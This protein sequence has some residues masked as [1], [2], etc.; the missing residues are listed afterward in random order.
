[1]TRLRVVLAMAWRESRASRR[2]L[3]L[4]ASAISI[5]V[6]AL[7]AIGSFTANLET[8]VRREA[9]ELLG[10]DLAL[11]SR[12]PF[13]P[14]IEALL[15]S[16]ARAGVKVARRTTF[17]S[18]GYVRRT[19]GI[20]LVEVRAVGAGFPFYGDVL[21]NPPGL[22]RALDTG[23][24]A[25][26]DTS[27]LVAL[28]ARVG[29]TL[30]LGRRSFLIAAA[31][32]EVPGHLLGGL[33]AFG[34]QVYIPI[35]D[36]AGTGL[37][38][39][40]SRVRHSALFRFDDPKDARRLVSRHRRLF[41]QERVSSQ[42]AEETQSEVNDAL[43]DLS[44]FLQFVGLVALLLGGIGVA[45]GVGAFVA[46]KLETVAVLRCLGASRPLVFVIYLTQAAA[47]GLVAAGLGAG[48]GVA[49]QLLLPRFLRGVL[50][51]DVRVALELGPI[52]AGIGIG[53]AV[54]LLFAL[55]PL[56][57]VRLVSPLQAL[58][59]PFE[60]EAAPSRRDPWR[61]AT[62]GALAAFVLALCLARDDDPVVGLS[63]AVAIGLSVGI[64][65]LAARLA[66]ALARRVTLGE[67]VRARWPF[68][69]RQGIANLY[70]PRNQTRTVVVALGFGVALL[71]TLY[72]VQANLLRQVTRSTRAAQGR[73]NLV[74]ID[75]Q[76]DQ[77]DG[78]SGLVRAAHRP[79]LQSVPIVPM[80]I[81]AINGRPAGD[82]L[83][84][85]TARRPEEWSLRR[86]YRSTYRD[87]GTASERLV[88]GAWW[89]GRGAVSPGSPYPVSLST[90][91]AEDLRVGI[92]DAITWTV[93]GATVET[94]VVSLREVDW[95]RFEPNFFAV[96]STAAL[97]RA[98]HSM[99]LLT[100]A[101]GAADRALLQRAVA[102]R[103]PNVTSLDVALLQRTVERIMSR[104]ALA[105]RF[106]AALSLATG[107][108]VLLGAVA[109]G[110]LERIRE[111]AL[112][113]TLGAT[114]R[115]LERI[116]VAEY[117]ALG[118]LA[119]VV[120]IGLAVAGGWAFTRFVLDLEFAVPAL[121]LAAVFAL[122]TLLVALVGVT[123]SREVFRRTAMEVLRDV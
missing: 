35:R 80:R 50:P 113:K 69:A 85:T 66:V 77:V 122:T 99:V 29:D 13:T 96:F 46:G 22:W 82:L 55:R 51:V 58:R 117:V 106:M 93:Q 1:M 10:A 98:P 37:I 3:L 83:K 84:D 64:L 86:E 70:R 24:V 9:R 31:V 120:G 18:M 111:G 30:E 104:V 107:A 116:L 115:Q 53:V 92:G 71:A 79:L 52:L 61:L 38:V 15:D 95:A 112:L 123:A 63:F 54:A 76:P 48:L 78:V 20:R 59:R 74:F 109:A 97:E 33:N 75:I 89:R 60:T 88:K 25:V 21:T 87:T 16:A 14:P 40:G 108:L 32:S 7:V 72:L 49:V 5:G 103:F 81:A 65:V 27:L 121:P 39:F 19:E 91:I 100:R 8:A 56:L 12:R 41:E 67:R 44:N 62:A 105:I 43:D 34:A 4:F 114:R 90:D 47:L 28:G 119:A 73:P 102:E 45:S 26:V 42:T 94:R 101:A 23:G 110:R 57:E 36:V 68:V 11:S 2:R 17:S 6:A 118:V